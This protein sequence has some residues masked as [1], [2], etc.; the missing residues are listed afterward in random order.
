M[1]TQ[2]AGCAR[3]WARAFKLHRKVRHEKRRG[4]DRG[5]EGWNNKKKTLLSGHGEH[6]QKDTKSLTRPMNRLPTAGELG[7]RDKKGGSS[8]AKERQM[9]GGYDAW[10]GR[11]RRNT[12]TIKE[13]NRFQSENR[14]S[15]AKEKGCLVRRKSEGASMGVLGTQSA[16]V[17]G[18]SS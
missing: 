16:D 3:A 8:W 5:R 6:R 14:Q 13:E 9:E 2:G 12:A 10:K 11:E 18:G 1:R 15:A 4:A 7:L 17:S